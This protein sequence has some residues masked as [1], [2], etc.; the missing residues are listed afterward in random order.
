MIPVIGLVCTDCH[1]I[2]AQPM[3]LEGVIESESLVAIAKATQI[4]FNARVE[5]LR[6][7]AQ[8]VVLNARARLPTATGRQPNTCHRVVSE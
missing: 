7:A 1:E 2:L 8:Q 5:K 3:T 6:K 4:E